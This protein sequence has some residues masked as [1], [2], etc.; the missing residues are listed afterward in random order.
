MLRR[1]AR[2]RLLPKPHAITFSK[3]IINQHQQVRFFH[4]QT[5][6]KKM[7]AQFGS[8]IVRKP[9]TDK[10]EYRVVKLDNQLEALLVFDSEAQL[11]SAAMDVKGKFVSTMDSLP[12]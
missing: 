9:L 10:R 3:A 5:P 4:N 6:N 11:A 2:N 7:S 12:I 1:L 8:E